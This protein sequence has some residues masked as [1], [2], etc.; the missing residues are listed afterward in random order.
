M[1]IRTDHTGLFAKFN[2]Q[3]IIIAG[4]QDPVMDFNTIKAIAIRCESEFESLPG[5]HLAFLEN[6]NNLLKILHFID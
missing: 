5:G 1:K 2:G 4:K 3:K 6:K